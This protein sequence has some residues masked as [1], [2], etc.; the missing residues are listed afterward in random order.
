MINISYHVVARY[1]FIKSCTWWQVFEIWYGDR[2]GY[3]GFKD[4]RKQVEVSLWWSDYEQS[5]MAATGTW[6]SHISIKFIIR[7]KY[8]TIFAMF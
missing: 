2:F 6:K 4:H 7:I 3:K 1:E 5:N 8:D